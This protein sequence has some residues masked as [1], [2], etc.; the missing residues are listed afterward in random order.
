MQRIDKKSVSV[1]ENKEDYKN[2]VNVLNDRIGNL[3]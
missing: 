3:E 2:A 1:Y